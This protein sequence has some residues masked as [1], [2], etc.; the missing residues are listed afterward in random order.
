LSGIVAVVKGL[1]V[2]CSVIF[3]E[4]GARASNNIGSSVGINM[5]GW[6]GRYD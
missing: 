3:L 6:D 5:E 4:D 1:G 2:V